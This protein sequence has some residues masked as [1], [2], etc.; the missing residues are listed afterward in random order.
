M[1]Q[2]NE[3][4][5]LFNRFNGLMQTRT[6]ILD[7]FEE[8]TKLENELEKDDPYQSSADMIVDNIQ[9]LQQKNKVPQD[10]VG[11]CHKYR[12]YTL[13]SEIPN[14]D[15]IKVLEKINKE[16][17][18][19]SPEARD[20]EQNANNLETRDGE[21]EWKKHLRKLLEKFG[22]F[23]VLDITREITLLSQI[24][25]IQDEL[26]MMQKVFTE[27]NKVL[28]ALDRIIRAMEQRDSDS[29]DNMQPQTLD[30]KLHYRG[31][32]RRRK[33]K[34]YHP[35]EAQDRFSDSDYS[36]IDTSS[37]VARALTSGSDFQKRS[38]SS[39]SKIWGL[40]HQENNLP[41]RTVTR[42]STQIQEMLKR[43]KTTN[44]AEL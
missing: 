24:K 16:E 1:V 43:A 23:Y 22:R 36:G 4:T 6:K 10:S 44:D 27:Q 5:L 28:K 3:E 7:K 9:W 19:K 20:R 32:S 38:Y 35:E 8:M 30:A 21:Q 13:E 42:H 31:V 17:K 15:D 18:K 2:M 29:N 34:G 26:E 40:G 37:T 25:D 14:I 11:L 33:T 39:Q 41:L 12:A